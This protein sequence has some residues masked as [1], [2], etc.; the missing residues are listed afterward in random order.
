MYTRKEIQG[1]ELLTVSLV[2]VQWPTHNAHS[3][4]CVFVSNY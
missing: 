4:K 2:K 3:T 1:F